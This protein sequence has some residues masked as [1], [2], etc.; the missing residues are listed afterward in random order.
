MP[1]TAQPAA[2][3]R[4]WPAAGLCRTDSERWFP[5]TPAESA[6]AKRM[7][8]NCPSL[9]PCRSWVLDSSTPIISHGVI[10]GLTTTDREEIRGGR[11]TVDDAIAWGVANPAP[12]EK[13]R[14]SPLTDQERD[15]IR[16][17]PRSSHVV[18]RE[19]GVSHTTVCRVR[20]T[21]VGAA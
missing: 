7:C 20:R 8:G 3:N 13:G 17:D 19:Y 12:L 1:N 14:V 11:R 2:D 6:D 5:T 9:E 4:G 16:R 18:G 10:G 15:E 21:L